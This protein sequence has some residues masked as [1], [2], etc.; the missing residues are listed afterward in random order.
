MPQTL[1]EKVWERHIVHRG[2]AAVVILVPP[3]EVLGS[4]GPPAGAAGAG[5]LEHLGLVDR[6][7]VVEV[8]DVGSGLAHVGSVEEGRLEVTGGVW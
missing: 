3:P 7:T 1:S 6:V 4:Q 2:E 5:G 8:H